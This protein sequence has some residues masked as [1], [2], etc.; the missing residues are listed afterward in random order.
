MLRAAGLL[1]PVVAGIHVLHPSG[2][3]RTSVYARVGSLGDP[4]PLLFALAEFALV[5]VVAGSVGLDRRSLY[6]GGA[7]VT[8]SLLAGVVLRHTVLEHGVFRPHPQ[9]DC[10]PDRRAARGRGPPP[11]QGV[12]GRERHPFRYSDP[13]ST[14]VIR[15]ERVRRRYG[16]TAALDGVS[17][18]VEKGTVFVLA[19]PNGAGKTT[20]IRALT[21]TT[22]VDGTV[23]LFG[24][25]PSEVS[26]ERIGLLPQEFAPADRLTARELVA[27]YGGLYDES[28]DVDT[29]LEDVGLTEAADT[30]YEDLSGGQKRRVCVGTALVN[31]PELLVLD[32][33][34]TGVDP[35]GRRE[36]WGVIEGL[37]ERGTTVVLT[38]HYMAEA[39]RLADRVGL[40]A[41][42][43]LVA[44]G[45]PAELLE[46]HGGADRL[47]VAVDDQGAAARALERADYHVLPDERH[48]AVG[49]GPE[50]IP[51]VVETLADAGVDYERL[52]WRQPDLEDV[53]LALAGVD[54]DPQELEREAVRA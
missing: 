29:V 7:A 22:R 37:A 54:V 1:A 38:T 32:E 5:G 21:G 24:K 2:R 14:M 35:A 6:L 30:H 11:F 20:L 36:L 10:H 15:A 46:R 13:R 48:L 42:G 28:R 12:I 44:L 8:L 52:T 19:G 23:E 4:R 9:A 18:S 40:L 3:G 51:A 45:S 25:P 47:V 27:Y 16:E 50:E 17:L 41:D 39:E 26:G 49:V 53:Y 43:R 31:D 34:T 33:P